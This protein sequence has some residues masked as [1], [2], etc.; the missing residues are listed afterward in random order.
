[1]LFQTLDD[2]SECVGVF[3]DDKLYFEQKDFPGY[4]T[5]T[6]KFAPYLRGLDVEYASLYLEG[7]PIKSV[8]PEYLQDDWED[9]S[10][11]VNAFK[12][13]LTQARVDLNE[14]CFYDL[15][16]H[17][18]L[19]DLCRVKNKITEHVLNNVGR[20]KRYDFYKHV[21]MLVDEISQH[22][23]L[24][25]ERKLKSFDN[26]TKFSSYLKSMRQF[27]YVRYNQ[28]GTKTGRL[29]TVRHSFPILTLPKD[30]RSAI[31]PHNDYYL[32]LDFNGAEV[33]TLLGLLGKE[34][35][36]GDVH[37]FHLQ[38]VFGKTKTRAEA[39]VAF[40]AWL[41]GSTQ[42]KDTEAVRRLEKFY[43]KNL[44][45]QK[46]Y[47]D[48]TITTPFGKVITEVSG[49]HAVNYLVQ[50]TAAE[51]FLKQALKIDYLLREKS[52]GS[53]VAY[54]LHDAI[55]IDM[56]K[57]DNDLIPVLC[58]LMSSTNFGTFGINIKRGSTLGMLE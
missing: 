21:C 32:E 47:A 55:I 26:V 35:P 31:L 46:H 33:R 36:P 23:V 5:K 1:M 24:L 25:D 18:F 12:R 45:L 19:V 27:G 30:L 44:L 34:Q 43:P 58:H 11:K 48:N 10:K 8:I 40:F 39:K 15:V 14:N 2:K 6:W 3:C 20:P 7:K 56:K 38:E 52:S 51:L 41:Y 9:V 16:P 4:L 57:S 29:T 50:S 22:R 13:S 17:R 53:R 54:L 28:F 37:D 49:H 42:Q